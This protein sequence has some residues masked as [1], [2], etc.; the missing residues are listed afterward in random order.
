MA[1]RKPHADQVA[2][3]TGA[4]SGI[5]RALAK[6][7][8]EEGMKV[9]LADVDARDLS[10]TAEDLR[11]FGEGILPVVTDVTQWEQVEALAGRAFKTFGGVHLLCNNA[12]VVAGQGQSVWD[13]TLEDW[14]W[15]FRVNFWGVLHG[16]R[17]FVP[18]LLKQEAESW[19]VNTAS[20][21]GVV[22]GT[23]SYAVA[24][25]A[26]VALSESLRHDLAG[27]APHIHVAVLCPG[28][29]NTRILESERHRP[30]DLER[31]RRVATAEEQAHLRAV[32]AALR[33]GSA[34]ED[35]AA[36][37]IEGIARRTFYILPHRYWDQFISD[38]S[39][40]ILEGRSPKNPMGAEE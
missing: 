21:T 11:G 17:A 18:L 26:V 6:R 28:G 22:C 2:V 20:L 31:G 5:G 14:E 27:R 36:A 33:A 37:V 34:P 19:I 30:A 13:T 7:C 24:K 9:V 10:A 3:I 12:G 32:Q 4:A 23:G 25:H 39:Q 16:L 1:L 38:R 8:L 35:M 15:Q 29:V 40:A